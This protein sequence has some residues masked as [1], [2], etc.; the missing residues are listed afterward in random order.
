MKLGEYLHTNNMSLR[1]FAKQ[2]GIHYRQLHR[3]VRG[4]GVPSLLNAY[5]IWKASKRKVRLQDWID[6]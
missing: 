6:K 5:K 4:E 2:T 3:Y 1:F